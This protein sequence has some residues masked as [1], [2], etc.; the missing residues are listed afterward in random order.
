MKDVWGFRHGT[1]KPNGCHVIFNTAQT[2]LYFYEKA[3][4][5]DGKDGFLDKKLVSS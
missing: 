5:A 2:D 4:W 1:L 3:L